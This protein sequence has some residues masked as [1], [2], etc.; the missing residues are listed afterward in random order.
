MNS[1]SLMV[2]DE[3]FP[4]FFSSFC[5][6][7]VNCSRKGPKFHQASC[8]E[9]SYV[10][11]WSIIFTWV[12]PFLRLYNLWRVSAR[13]PPDVGRSRSPA[14]F[15]VRLSRAPRLRKPSQHLDSGVVDPFAVIFLFH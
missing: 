12:F 7:F 15:L 8:H 1:I 14:F 9:T 5:V 10:S 11:N 6:S 3:D 13:S 4:G 2:I